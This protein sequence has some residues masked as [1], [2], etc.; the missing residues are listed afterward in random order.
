[1]GLRSAVTGS[2]ALWVA[3]VL[4]AAARAGLAFMPSMAAWG[5]NVMRFLPGWVAWPL[6]LLSVL[7]LVPAVGKWLAGPWLGTRPDVSPKGA[8]EMGPRRRRQGALARRP[9]HRGRARR[10]AVPAACAAGAA[11]LVFAIPDRTCY[12]GDFMLRQGA[13][14]EMTA[15]MA[16]ERTVFKQ[17]LPLDRL[18]HHSLPRWLLS[19]FQ[20]DANQSARI[21]GMADAAGLALIAVALPRVLALTGGAALAAGAIVFFGG[22][23]VLFTGYGKAVVELGVLAGAA[24]VAGLG[25]LRTGRGLGL[26]GVLLALALPLHRSAVVLLPMAIFTWIQWLRR[27]GSRIALR[28][29]AVMAGVLLPWVVLAFVAQRIVR[30]FLDVDIGVHLKPPQVAAGGG[31]LRTAF[32]PLRMLDMANIAVMLSPVVPAALAAA[33][34]CAARRPNGPAPGTAVSV[35][36]PAI[37]RRSEILLLLLLLLPLLVAMVFVHPAQGMFR[38]WDNSI[39]IGVSLSVLTAW[40]VGEALREV[41]QWGWLGLAAALGAAGPALQWMIHHHDVDLGMR[42]IHAFVVEPPPRTPHERVAALDFL[43]IRHLHRGEYD[44]AAEI[45]RQMVELAPSPRFHL[46][47]ALAEAEA[48]H[49]AEAMAVYERLLARIPDHQVAWHGYTAMASRLGLW[50][51]AARGAKEVLRRSPGDAEATRLLQSIPPQVHRAAPD[52]TSNGRAGM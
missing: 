38:D 43:G 22:Y 1:M 21:I 42:R 23:L 31:I 6:W 3:L 29:P 11:L 7:P 35:P 27:P 13:V 36:S 52:S 44:Q 46:Q 14:N 45:F 2:R 25:V 10:I 39:V 18:L 9:R 40:I 50:R 48:G 17:A 28:H 19:R 51:E 30:T 26:F 47:W 24:A 16:R 37:P 33:I 12:V 49:Y 5:M 20:I 8:A 15:D 32:T 41:P 34:G 4:L